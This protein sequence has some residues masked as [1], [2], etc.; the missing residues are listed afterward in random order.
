MRLSPADVLD[1]QHATSVANARLIDAAVASGKYVWAAFGDQDGVGGGPSK[2]TCATWMRDR[3]GAAAPAYQN[4]AITQALDRANVN[5]SIASFLVTRPPIG[6][7]GF[8]WE[9]DMKDWIS[10][11][12]WQVGEPSTLCAE[13][14]SGVFKRTWTHGDVAL[15]CNTWTGTIPTA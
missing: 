2:A 13:G 5:Q 10:E 14:P 3:C 7:I 9:S 15:D 6:F 1:I 11:F 4:I 8:G 12:L